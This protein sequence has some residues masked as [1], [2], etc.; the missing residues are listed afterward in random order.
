[1]RLFDVAI[2]APS[3]SGLEKDGYS[4]ERLVIAV[5]GVCSECRRY[6]KGLEDGAHAM[7]ERR[8]VGEPTLA[9]AACSRHDSPIGPL[10]LG[11][12][13]TG[14]IRIAFEDHADFD[15]L[16]ERARTRRGSRVA[17]RRLEHAEAAID[18]FFA[19][20]EKQADDAFDPDG[21]AQADEA[22][23]E[24]T[25]EV[26]YGTT[27]SYDLLADGDLDPYR[28]GYAFGTNPMPIIFPCHRITRGDEQ[29]SAYVGGPRRREAMLQVERNSSDGL[30][31]V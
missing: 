8:L 5:G 16:L 18:S 9:T 27:L 12:T 11:A 24:A 28:L 7:I 17:R 1:M 23:L 22:A 20:S 14:I 6:E 2:G 10:A 31:P 3:T 29:P 13:E 21:R 19:G 25:R 15:P 26:P 4:V 30:R